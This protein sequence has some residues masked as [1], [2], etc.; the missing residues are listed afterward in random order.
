MVVQHV[1][2]TM[3]MRVRP[4]APCPAQT[5]GRISETQA[6]QHPGSRLAAEG[7]DGNQ[8][9][10][11]R[12]Q[13]NADQAQGDRADEVPQAAP[14]R[15]ADRSRQAPLPGLGHGHERQVVVRAEQRMHKCDGSRRTGQ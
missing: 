4:T 5:P 14:Q 12:A 8:P 6:Q 9:R 2:V 13:P 3:P 1:A 15:D 10:Y 11:G 7:F